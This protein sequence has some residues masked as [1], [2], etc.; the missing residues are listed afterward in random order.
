M[1]EQFAHGYRVA[2]FESPR[3]ADAIKHARQLECERAQINKALA[4]DP[5]AIA[6][7]AKRVALLRQREQND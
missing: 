4:G 6:E 2:V 5:R 7:N 1:R 3:K